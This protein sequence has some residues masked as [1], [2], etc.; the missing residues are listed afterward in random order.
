MPR[1]PLPLGTWGRISRTEVDPGKWVARG[2]FR[3][4]D[5]RTRKVEAWGKTGAAA[6]RALVSALTDRVAPS[7][8]RITADSRISALAVLWLLELDRSDLASNSRHRYRELVDRH[9]IPGVG[10]LTIREATVGPLDRFLRS[11]A[12]NTG[13]ATAK[14]CRTVLSAMLGLAARHDAAPRNVVRDTS[15][16]ATER[17]PIRSLTE[18]EVRAL[19]AKL[20]TDKVAVGA[21]LPDLADYMLGT[22]VRIG[23][24]LALR[25]AD[26]DLRAEV[27]TVTITGTVIRVQGQGLAIQD[28]PKTSAGR[29]RLMLPP[30]VVAMLLRRQMAMVESNAW[31]LVFP[32]ATGTLR[33][34][35]NVHRQ[36]RAARDRAGFGWVTPHVFRKSVATVIGLG[37]LRAA[38]DQLGHSG[39]AVTERHYVQ[40]TG[41]GPDARHLLEVFGQASSDD[42]AP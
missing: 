9:V 3:D 22:G 28:H 26:L 17:K 8:D 31:D 38:A 13:P 34:P 36:W 35:Q 30:F 23:E 29:R 1:R 41:A 21:G 40:R 15:P 27:A 25:W 37:D 32:S 20:G 5:G 16:V 6:E 12:D 42:D 7:G 2:R 33:E 10:G 18:R 4:F 24:A 39:T 11:V 19:R 14:G